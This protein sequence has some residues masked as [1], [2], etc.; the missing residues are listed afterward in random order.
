MLLYFI[1]RRATIKLNK[2]AT[3]KIT[4]KIHCLQLFLVILMLDLL[5]DG[6][7]GLVIKLQFF[8]YLNR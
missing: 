3:I 6:L 8:F 4:L 1:G 7:D 5:N 2:I